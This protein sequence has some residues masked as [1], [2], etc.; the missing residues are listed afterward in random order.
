VCRLVQA[1][2]DYT[3]ALPFTPGL[4]AHAELGGHSLR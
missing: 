1:V 4:Q 2:G 3:I